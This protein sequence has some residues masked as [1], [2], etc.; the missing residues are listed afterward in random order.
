MSR[1]VVRDMKRALATGTKPNAAFTETTLARESALALLERSIG[2]G[3]GRLAVIRLSIAVHAGCDI[4]H[5][6]WAYCEE[7]V[8]N[9]RDDP[10]Q[11]IWLT[12]TKA[13]SRH[14]IA[15]RRGDEPS[16][17]PPKQRRRHRLPTGAALN[18]AISTDA[19]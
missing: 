17:A 15:P 19:A 10:L 14:A 2:F 18:A 13:A 4:P 11:S 12:A 1:Q 9:S 16:M 5:A 6:Y 3:H 8:H 7:V